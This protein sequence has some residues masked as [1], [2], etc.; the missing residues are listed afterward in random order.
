[1]EERKNTWLKKAGTQL[2]G[3]LFKESNPE[4]S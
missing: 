3:D 1:M 2:T 4:T